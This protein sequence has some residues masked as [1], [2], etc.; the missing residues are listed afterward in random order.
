MLGGRG[1]GR[2]GIISKIWSKF[3]ACPRTFLGYYKKLKK[4]TVFRFLKVHEHVFLAVFHCL[5]A[6]TRVLAYMEINISNNSFKMSIIWSKYRWFDRNIDDLIEML[7]FWSKCHEKTLFFTSIKVK[8]AVFFHFLRFF[9]LL[10]I[11]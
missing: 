6:S 1:G 11:T 8:N 2:W 5:R 9:E 7:L 10:V 4:S 3:W